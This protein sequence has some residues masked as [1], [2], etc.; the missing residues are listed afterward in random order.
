MEE[1]IRH[2]VAALVSKPDEIDIRSI[3]QAD[4]GITVEVRVAQE[5]MG[6]IIGKQGRIARAIRTVVKAASTAQKQRVSVEII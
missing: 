6:K 1:L 3:E 2:I 5:D 4:G